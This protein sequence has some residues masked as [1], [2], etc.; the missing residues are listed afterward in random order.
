MANSTTCG[1]CVVNS[2][3]SCHPFTSDA[4]ENAT[5]FCSREGGMLKNVCDAVAPAVAPAVQDAPAVAPATVTP[6]PCSSKAC[7]ECLGGSGCSF[8]RGANWGVCRGLDSLVNGETMTAFCAREG[9]AIIAT[10]QC[11]TGVA[12]VPAP[13]LVTDGATTD[14]DCV[15]R[16]TCAGCYENTA[17]GL[18]TLA[19]GNIACRGREL[20]V[21]GETGPQFCAREGGVWS[22]ARTTST[23]S[24]VCKVSDVVNNVNSGTVT[25]AA[26]NN[27]LATNAPLQGFIVVVT[28]ITE[29]SHNSDGSAHFQT[30]V[31]VT[32]A[33]EPTLDERKV[34][35]NGIASSLATHLNINVSEIKCAMT[36][37]VGVKRVTNSYVADLTVGQQTAGA[38]HV[39]AS[40]ALVA[41]AL[42]ATY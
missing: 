14:T 35:C 3:G 22:G 5:A 24:D 37:H 13:A 39:A 29:A 23:V 19:S 7:G 25:E 6:A 27:D 28:V 32:G 15:N 18:C 34:I 16:A 17:C 31:D 1:W 4:V 21:R 2:T 30:Y 9:G 10:G 41:T 11:E 12:V 36:L 26:V 42:F 8:C 33:A 38:F 20:T 40:L